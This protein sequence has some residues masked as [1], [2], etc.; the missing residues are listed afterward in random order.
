M[1]KGQAGAM[2]IVVLAVSVLIGAYLVGTV[3]EST[4]TQIDIATVTEAM[5]DTLNNAT[6]GLTLMAVAIIVGAAVFIL[7][8]MGGR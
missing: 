1:K 2:G 7:G 4:Y 5:N 3:Y 6:T 8:I